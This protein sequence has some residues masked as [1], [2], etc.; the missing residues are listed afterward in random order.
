MY[1]YITIEVVFSSSSRRYRYLA[2]RSAGIRVGERVVVD[3]PADGPVAVTVV[4]VHG[5][6]R[7]IPGVRLKSILGVQEQRASTFARQKY[8]TPGE[9]YQLEDPEGAC[10]IVEGVLPHDSTGIMGW[11]VSEGIARPRLL[12]LSEIGPSTTIP[13][14]FLKEPNS[15]GLFVRG[16]TVPIAVEAFRFEKVANV[17]NPYEWGLRHQGEIWMA[18]L[19]I[20]NRSAI[21]LTGQ[22]VGSGIVLSD[23]FGYRHQSLRGTPLSALNGHQPLPQS[24]FA[25]TW[26]GFLLHPGTITHGFLAF[27]LSPTHGVLELCAM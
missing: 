15:L 19:S 20:A 4:E 13:G 3:S 22:D 27:L 10:V 24:L 12:D 2:P 18:Q 8:V 16:S 5:E 21:V 9:A 23:T 14:T 26:K 11:I 1:D 25:F 17:S 7:S 6:V